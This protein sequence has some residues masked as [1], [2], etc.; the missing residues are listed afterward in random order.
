M[1]F[2][3]DS[4]TLKALRPPSLSHYKRFS[5]SRLLYKPLAG[6]KKLGGR[7]ENVTSRGTATSSSLKRVLQFFEGVEGFLKIPRKCWS[8]FSVK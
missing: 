4:Q 7:R 2:F 6:F 1:D 5:E 3:V 8:V